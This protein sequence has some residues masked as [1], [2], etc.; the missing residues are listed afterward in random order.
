MLS[1]M[2]TEA[3]SVIWIDDCNRLCIQPD[4]TTF[5]MIY[6][7][8]MGVNWN[9]QNHYLYSQVMN[10]WTPIDWFRQILAAVQSEYEYHLYTTEKTEW[11]NIDKSLVNLIKAESVCSYPL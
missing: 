5:E 7:S 8:A 1:K 4:A 6:G 9:H 11:K 2:K 10:S 3:I